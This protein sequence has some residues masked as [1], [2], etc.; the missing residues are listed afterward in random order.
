MQSR[1]CLPQLRYVSENDL[2]PR[3]FSRKRHP[4]SDGFLE[5]DRHSTPL[6]GFLENDFQTLMVFWKTTDTVHP[7]MVFWK[8]TSTP[9]WFGKRPTQYT[10][11]FSENDHATMDPD[12][13]R[14]RAP[15][16]IY[17]LATWVKIVPSWKDF[18]HKNADAEPGRYCTG[19]Q[20]L[21]RAEKS[22]ASIPPPVTSIT[23][24]KSELRRHRRCS[25]GERVPGTLTVLDPG[26][27]SSGV[28]KSR[29]SGSRLR[30]AYIRK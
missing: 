21:S 14:Y 15:S 5:N 25:H 26:R 12:P 27:R 17:A 28:G 16:A 23:R 30:V 29:R 13:D 8:T 1:G 24:G 22:R 2:H 11:R 3:R 19:S 10:R 9:R 7:S 6:D 20:Q 18:E 4:P